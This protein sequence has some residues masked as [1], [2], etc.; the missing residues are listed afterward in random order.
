MTNLELLKLELPRLRELARS[1]TAEEAATWGRASTDALESEIR[2]RIETLQEF[3]VR[4]KAAVAQ[5]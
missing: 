2:W 4:L 5:P 1:A 3:G